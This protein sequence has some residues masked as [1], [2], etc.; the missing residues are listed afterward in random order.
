LDLSFQEQYAN[1]SDEELLHIAG[2]RRDLREEAVF[3]LDAEMARRGL[4]HEQARA[5]KRDGLRLEISMADSNQPV[6][7]K[8]IDGC[9]SL[10]L[11]A[12]GIVFLFGGK[13]FYEI[14][15]ENFLVS[16]V[17]GIAAGVLLMLLGA[18][19]AIADKSPKPKHGSPRKGS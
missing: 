18:G 17:G 2:D 15:H 16:E 12:G 3:V 14:K 9:S 5:K 1:L 8:I 10:L 6:L 7:Q 13:F 19:I 4:T 11:L